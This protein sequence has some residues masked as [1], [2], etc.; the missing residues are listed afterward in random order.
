MQDLQFKQ[1]PYNLTDYMIAHFKIFITRVYTQVYN[2]QA[3]AINPCLKERN[4]FDIPSTF[5]HAAG[6]GTSTIHTRRLCR[7]GD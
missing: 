6:D 3:Q 2:H 5:L 1:M 4:H 7:Y